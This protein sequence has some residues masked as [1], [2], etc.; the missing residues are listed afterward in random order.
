MVYL[1]DCQRSTS[2][3]CAGRRSVPLLLPRSRS[4][5][6][7]PGASS[8]PGVFCIVRLVRVGVAPHPS[9]LSTGVDGRGG[10]F[11]AWRLSRR[12]LRRCPGHAGINAQVPENVALTVRMTMVAGFAGTHQKSRKKDIR[13]ELS[14]CAVPQAAS[15]PTCFMV[16]APRTRGHSQLQ[17]RSSALELGLPFKRNLQ[18]FDNVSGIDQGISDICGGKVAGALRRYSK[19]LSARPWRRGCGRFLSARACRVSYRSSDRKDR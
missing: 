14:R 2:S 16:P 6:K 8:R 1:R 9:A 7:D 4:K 12:L 11:G 5:F 17:P 3:H 19:V 18:C 13:D 15:G 10:G